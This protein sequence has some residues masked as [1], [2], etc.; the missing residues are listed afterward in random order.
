[1]S[2]TA[3]YHHTNN[4][5]PFGNNNLHMLNQTL[6]TETIGE[7]KKFRKNSYSTLLNIDLDIL[8]ILI[9]KMDI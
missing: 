6:L 7:L 2:T 8:Q 4:T 3:H 5:W 9:R 1:M